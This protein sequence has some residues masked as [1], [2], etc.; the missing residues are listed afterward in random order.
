MLEK[1][2]EQTELVVYL[3]DRLV[4]RRAEELC[5][6]RCKWE[7][8]AQVYGQI[9]L[10]ERYGAEKQLGAQNKV[11]ADEYQ[12]IADLLLRLPYGKAALSKRDV[13]T[14]DKLI[15]FYVD[16]FSRLRDEATA[17]VRALKIVNSDENFSKAQA[18]NNIYLETRQELGKKEQYFRAGASWLSSVKLEL[19]DSEE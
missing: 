9:H 11:Q 12:K 18:S 15:K 6:E 17:Q 7:A 3:L 10:E 2:C 19:E 16:D 14:L 4:E 8:I 1:D 5:K 13:A